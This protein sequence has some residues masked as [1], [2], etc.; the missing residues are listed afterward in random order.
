MNS[1]RQIF[2]ALAVLTGVSG[3]A[4]PAAQ[5][6]PLPK[7][8]NISAADTIDGLA[9]TGIPAEHQA[10]MPGV[11]KQLNGLQ[12]LNQLHQLTDL[13]APVTQLVPSVQ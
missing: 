7:T 4:V 9:T 5:A 3:L 8:T 1:T 6:A 12:D 10:E 11:T 2:T 13:V